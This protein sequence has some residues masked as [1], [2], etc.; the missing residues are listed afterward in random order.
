MDTGGIEVE[1]V[2]SFSFM[3][4][5]LSEL[6]RHCFCCCLPGLGHRPV[7]LGDTMV[8]SGRSPAGRA[9]CAFICEL[10]FARCLSPRGPPGLPFAFVSGA[11]RSVRPS[12]AAPPKSAD[13]FPPSKASSLSL[14][15]FLLIAATLGSFPWQ[16]LALERNSARG[17]GFLCAPYPVGFPSTQNMG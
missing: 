8:A 13:S 3:L 15:L 1:R 16:S 17:E 10:P 5:I 2:R 11:A 7:S 12:P 9:S 4:S 6:T 14:A